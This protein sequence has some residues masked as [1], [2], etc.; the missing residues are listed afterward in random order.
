MTRGTCTLLMLSLLLLTSPTMAGPP[1]GKKAPEGPPITSDVRVIHARA[2][3]T[4]KMDA[5]LSDV[6]AYLTNGL[7]ARYNDFTV[8]DA[9]RFE[10]KPGDTSTLDVK[11]DGRVDLTYRGLRDG[12]LRFKATFQDLT[13]R[14]KLADGGYFIQAGRGFR[15]GILVYLIGARTR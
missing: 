11:E 12:L 8:L 3:A 6:A 15:D 9:R 4:P 14:V 5:R 2:S 13:V 1:P 10:Q 7:G